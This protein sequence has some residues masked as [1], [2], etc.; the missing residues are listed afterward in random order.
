[1]K[2]KPAN[3]IYGVDDKPPFVTTVFLGLQHV[4]VIFIAMIF[5]VMI[6]NHLGT[7][8]DP[9]TASGFISITMISSGIVT[10]LQALKKGPVGSGYL[11]PSVC[12]PSY[13]Q[14]SFMAISS[15]GLPV[16]FGMTAFVGVA[17]SIFSRFMH[18]LRVLFPAEVT[19]TIVAMVG[20]TIIP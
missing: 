9:R 1:M 3:L 13:L 15:G 20:I 6:V 19:G 14:A 4:F 10:I 12:G 2:K 11:C 7:S 18:K 17:E 5:P 8:I 16:L